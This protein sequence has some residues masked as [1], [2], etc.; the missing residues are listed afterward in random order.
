MQRFLART[1][2]GT[3]LT[4]AAVLASGLLMAAPAA[5]ATTC[6]TSMVGNTVASGTCSGTGEFR[7]VADCKAP[8]INDAYSS[9][10]RVDGGSATVRV[11]CVFGINRK[12]IQKR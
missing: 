9:W 1:T 3:T 2:A 10:V 8:Q 12:F 4:A 11:E 5:A 7:L 6:S